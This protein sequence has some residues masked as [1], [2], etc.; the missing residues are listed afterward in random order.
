MNLNDVIGNDKKQRPIKPSEDEKNQ[1]IQIS[2]ESIEVIAD[3]IGYSDIG[4]PISTSLA[5][6]LSYR[7]RELLQVSFFKFLDIERMIFIII[8]ILLMDIFFRVVFKYYVMVKS[9]SSLKMML[10]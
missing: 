3:S 6:D 7:L 5:E 4:K 9:Q 8:I 2:S 10:T 1:F